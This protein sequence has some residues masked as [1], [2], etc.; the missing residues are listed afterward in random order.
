MENAFR[1][2]ADQL[3]VP[4]DALV[5]LVDVGATMTAERATQPAQHLLART[6]SAASSLPTR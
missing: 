1:L 6:G 4:K 5:A 2:I 3:S